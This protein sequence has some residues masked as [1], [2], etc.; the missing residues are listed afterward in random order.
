MVRGLRQTFEVNLYGQ[1]AVTEAFEPLLRKSKKPYLI[2]VSSEQGSITQRLNPDYPHSKVRGDHY[3]V[4]KAALN[5]Y[6]A[7]ARYNYAEWGCAV[8]AFNPGWCITNLTG[9][10]G[11]KVR[12]ELGARD[13]RDP[14]LAIVDIVEGKRDEDMKKNGMLDVDGGMVP[15]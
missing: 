4:S 14:A 11:R 5:M 10:D 12:A 6:V 8:V 2:Y 3:R 15:W 1:V 9:E 7:C 13:P